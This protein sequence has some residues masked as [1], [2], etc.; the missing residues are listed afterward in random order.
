MDTLARKVAAVSSSIE[1]ATRAGHVPMIARLILMGKGEIGALPAIARQ[2]G[3]P[4]HSS[5][6]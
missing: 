4:D 3:I 2:R 1:A 6:W 5:Q